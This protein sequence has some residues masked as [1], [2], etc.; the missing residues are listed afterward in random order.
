[1]FIFNAL[2][3]VKILAS[4]VII[5]VMIKTIIVDVNGMGETVV[6]IM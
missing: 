1:M 5:F 4:K 2:I 3:P 6:V